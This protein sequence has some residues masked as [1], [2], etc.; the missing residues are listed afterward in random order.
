MCTVFSELPFS[1]VCLPCL[2]WFS[3]EKSMLAFAHCLLNFKTFSANPWNPQMRWE[4]GLHFRE[5]ARCWHV[6]HIWHR[7]RE[8]NIANGRNTL[9]PWRMHVLANIHTSKWQSH[10]WSFIFYERAQE[11]DTISVTPWQSDI[12]N[13]IFSSLCKLGD[14]SEW[15]LGSFGACG[16]SFLFSSLLTMYNQHCSS[17]LIPNSQNGKKNYNY[18]LIWSCH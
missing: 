17:P 15:F 7:N 13:D 18:G 3:T 6:K 14:K 2:L 5:R 12:W 8:V 10:R 9:A 4:L 1:N 11:E 16:L